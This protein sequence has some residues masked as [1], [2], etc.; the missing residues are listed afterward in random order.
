MNIGTYNI[1]SLSTDVK[2]TELEDGLQKIKFD[3]IEVYETRHKGEGCLILSNSGYHLYYKGGNTFYNGVGFVVNKNI[4]GN[5]TNFNGVSDRVAQWTIKI[6][7]GY[8]INVIQVY[9]PTTGHADEEVEI[10]NENVNKLLFTSK[11]NHTIFMGDFNA[12]VGIGNTFKSSTGPYSYGT[13]NSRVDTLVNFA[14]HYQLKI[15]NMFSK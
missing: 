11:A 4:A 12:K 6:N 8:L 1:R 9:L 14:E 10:V 5:I 15:M 3:V 13:R 7:K 2:V